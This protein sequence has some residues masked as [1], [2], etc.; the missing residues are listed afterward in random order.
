LEHGDAGLMGVRTP[1]DDVPYEPPP[2]VGPSAISAIL[3]GLALLAVLVSHRRQIGAADARPTERVA[4]S[5][6]QQGN[7]DLDEYPDVEEPFARQ[8]GNHRV[9][10]Y[11][12]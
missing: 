1:P 6:V 5:L 11:P 4:A 2:R 10:V 12:V 8:K 3:L 9:S 7:L